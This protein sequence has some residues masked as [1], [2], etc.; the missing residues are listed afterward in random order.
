MF[1]CTICFAARFI[2]GQLLMN[3]PEEPEFSNQ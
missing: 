1:G 3:F 2:V